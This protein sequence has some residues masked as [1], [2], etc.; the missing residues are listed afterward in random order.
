MEKNSKQSLAQPHCSPLEI[1]Q[2]Q[3]PL[4]SG[5]LWKS[6]WE[7][8][9]PLLVATV[10]SSIVALVNVQVAGLLGPAAQAAVGLAEQFI[11]IFQVFIMSVGV[12][13]T[14]LVSRA[15]GRKDLAEAN[16]A[17]AQSLS[18]SLLIGLTLTAAAIFMAHFIVPFLTQER[19]VNAQCNLY[20][21]IYAL[22]VVPYSFVCI[23][24]A[25]FR[26]IGSVRISL[27]I[28]CVE[29]IVNILGDYLTVLYNWP[30]A[31]LGVRGIAASA[32]LGALIAALVALAFVRGSQLKN[33]LNQILPL[34]LPLLKRIVSIGLPAALQRLSWAFSVF[35]LFFILS[36]APNPTAALAAWTIGMRV[37]GILF[38]PE[39]ALS[40][41]V[42]S[43]VGQNLGAK[44]VD[45]AFRAGW[46]VCGL[47]VILI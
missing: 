22:Y 27:L 33:S 4:V 13:T 7:M 40:L 10:V 47:A 8:S 11:F 12:S 26:A 38:M 23:V 41:A 6:I 35:G 2:I 21:T 32:F 44:R 17:T 37:E 18:L 43:I 46:S 31:G 25:A 3:S 36:K 5:S 34:S 9:W 39:L 19:E 1:S 14:A 29:V 16:F 28:I 20:L 45:R 24:N 30:I 15:Y 42:S